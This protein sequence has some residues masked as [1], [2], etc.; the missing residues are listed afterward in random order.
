MSR[1]LA[2][3]QVLAGEIGPRGTGSPGE[4]AA[5]RYVAGRV[6]A[7]GLPVEQQT[8]RAVGSQNAFPLSIDA[9]ALLAFVV[10]TFG[11]APGRW[12]GAALAL[13]TAPFLWQTIRTSRN[14]LRPL[15]PKVTSRNVVACIELRSGVR[16]RAVRSATI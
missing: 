14:P 9:L 1:T 12:V 16:E 15:L 3:V 4:E 5:A 11:R 8:F 6:S 7:L 10:Y 13:A 2:D